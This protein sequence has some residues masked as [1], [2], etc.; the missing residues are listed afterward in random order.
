MRVNMMALIF[1]LKIDLAKKNTATVVVQE[2]MIETNLS[3][4]VFTP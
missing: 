4:S 3:M 1:V 2:I